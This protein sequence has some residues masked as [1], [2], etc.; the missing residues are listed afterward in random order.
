MREWSEAL[1]GAGIDYLENKSCNIG[2]DN[3]K[4]GGH[5]QGKHGR[6]LKRLV[7]DFADS[8]RNDPNPNII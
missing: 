8:H 7:R 4:V 3:S 2:N 1:G 6:V 5:M